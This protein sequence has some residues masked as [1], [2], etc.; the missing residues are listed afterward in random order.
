[1]IREGQPVLGRILLAHGAG[2]PMDSDF[3]AS[4]AH[5]LASGGLEVIRFEFP[6]MQ[7]RREDGKRRPP[8]R[9]PKLLEFFEALIEQFSEPGLP[10]FIAGKSMG[11]RM[12]TMLADAESVH[13]CFVYG[14]P[15]YA[16]GKSDKPRVDHFESMH[17]P[18]HIFQ[19]TRDPMGNREAVAGYQLAECVRVH[20]LEDGDHDLKP[21]KKSG[22]NQ[23]EH[24]S[25]A[26][27]STLQY[28]QQIKEGSA[29]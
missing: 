10:L 7:K 18:V 14:Y 26:V 9:Q 29:E 6:Y 25:F 23:D 19:G 20:W 27:E 13:G 8:D 16:P 3:M 2:A 22:L 21:R 24:I 11:G 5:Q 28:C 15:F 12:A 17:T 4:V 1:M